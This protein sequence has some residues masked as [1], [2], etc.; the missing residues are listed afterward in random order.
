MSPVALTNQGIRKSG[1]VRTK[2]Q[3]V[4]GL[5]T[6]E[7][8]WWRG[9][10]L[11]YIDHCHGASNVSGRPSVLRTNVDINQMSHGRI[12]AAPRPRE[13]RKRNFSCPYRFQK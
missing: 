4:Y 1:E 5:N 10:W 6:D 3:T 7:Y 12:H 13:R 2:I 8:L 9:E 11:K